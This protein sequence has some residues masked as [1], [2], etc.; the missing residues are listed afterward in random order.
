MRLYDEGHLLPDSL[1]Q[2]VK[3]SHREHDAIVRDGNLEL[4]D[5]VAMLL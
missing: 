1:S 4:I 5:F 2:L 3:L